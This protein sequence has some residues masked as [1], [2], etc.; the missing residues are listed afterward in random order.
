M[1]LSS[2][3][4]VANQKTGLLEMYSPQIKR[5]Y[6]YDVSAIIEAPST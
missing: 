1:S 6:F 5:N 3:P 4:K 2:K